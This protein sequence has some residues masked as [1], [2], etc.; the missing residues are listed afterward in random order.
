M[1]HLARWRILFAVLVFYLA[2][3]NTSLAQ[4]FKTLVSFTENNGANPSL[5]QGTD[6]N[7]YGTIPALAFFR[8]LRNASSNFAIVIR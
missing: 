6:G 8:R 3:T 5:I 1:I 7:F 4:E 2:T